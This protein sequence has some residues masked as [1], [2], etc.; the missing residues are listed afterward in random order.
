MTSSETPTAGTNVHL[1]LES[2]RWSITTRRVS[3]SGLVSVDYLIRPVGDDTGECL[4]RVVFPDETRSLLTIMSWT[5]NRQVAE[6]IVNVGSILL[7]LHLRAGGAF[8][9][10]S[11]RRRAD[12]GGTLTFM[13]PM[14]VVRAYLSRYVKD[15]DA[16]DRPHRITNWETDQ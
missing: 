11:A 12:G 5:E 9:S 4:A 8:A 14:D 13:P 3:L 15:D 16:S 7:E 6:A 10:E 1:F 2:P